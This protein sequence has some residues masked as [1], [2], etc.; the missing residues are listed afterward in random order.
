LFSALLVLILGHPVHSLLALICSFI[1]IS[2]L[3]IL[4]KVEYFGF[5]FLIVYVGA[6]SILF[7]FILMLFDLSVAFQHRYLISFKKKLFTLS[8]VLTLLKIYFIFTA[9]LELFYDFYVKKV[10]VLL[11]QRL[12]KSLYLNVSEIFPVSLHLYKTYGISFFFITILLLSAMIGSITIA[13]QASTG[14][15]RLYT[16]YTRL[17]LLTSINMTNFNFLTDFTSIFLIRG[18]RFSQEVLRIIEIPEKEGWNKDD[19]RRVS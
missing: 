7:L 1:Q 13:T 10:E 12:L 14:F 9:R 18:G 5:V 17:N 8:L 2:I 16:V 11:G 19:K 3:L 4:N 6:V 15:F